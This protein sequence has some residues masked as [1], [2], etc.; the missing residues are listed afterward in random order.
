MT[1]RLLSHESLD[2]KDLHLIHREG[3]F[4]HYIEGLPD[5]IQSEVFSF[6]SYFAQVH[7]SSVQFGNQ[8]FVIV[9]ENI[10]YKESVQYDSV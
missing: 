6:C 7:S 8:E 9:K 10:Q 3:S 4:N 1:D 2:Q 5:T